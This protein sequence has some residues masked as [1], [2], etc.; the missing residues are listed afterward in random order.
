MHFSVNVPKAT[1]KNKMKINS[2]LFAPQNALTVQSKKKIAHNA[3]HQKN[4]LSRIAFVHT[5]VKPVLEITLLNV[6]PAKETE[7]F[8]QIAPAL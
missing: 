6:T 8:L 4:I 2:A 3:P 5:S 7:F 1:L